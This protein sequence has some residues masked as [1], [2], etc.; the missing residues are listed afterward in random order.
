MSW[1]CFF[2]KDLGTDSPQ[3]LHINVI[4]LVPYITGLISTF[5]WGED[6]LVIV[7]ALSMTELAHSQGGIMECGG[8]GVSHRPVFEFSFHQLVT[9]SGYQIWVIGSMWK[10]DD[11]PHWVGRGIK[12]GYKCLPYWRDLI[13]T[14]ALSRSNFLNLMNFAGNCLK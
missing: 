4:S 9:C 11:T 12:C 7:W 10:K 8:R 6:R 2:I 14:S 1:I 13:N 5:N 3:T